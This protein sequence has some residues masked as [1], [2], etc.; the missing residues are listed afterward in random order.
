MWLEKFFKKQ[1]IS[2]CKEENYKC[3]IE[4]VKNK[5]I[6]ST[7]TKEFEEGKE[8]V[9]FIK[10][11]IEENPQTYVST[12]LF[13]INQGVVPSCNKQTYLKY[14]IDIDNVT[15]VCINNKYSFYASNYE[16]INLKREYGFEIDFIYSVFAVMDYLATERKN[17]FYVLALKN[18]IAILGYEN[19]IPI[20]HDIIESDAHHH[21]T[22]TEVEDID[23]EKDII[24]DINDIESIEEED[25]ETPEDEDILKEMELVDILKEAIKEYYEHYS[26]DFIEKIIILD[27][28]GLDIT[29][30]KFIED[31]LLIPSEIKQIDLL[32]SINRLSIESI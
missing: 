29:L 6:L 17:R 24:S 5:K 10:S 32:N 21:A 25:I 28:I 4:T 27:T 3:I 30:N 7:E 22:S 11:K 18:K 9:R 19:L 26:S 12:V 15:T 31:E 16:I 2:F 23:F 8:F 20:F 13:T 1:F 14:E